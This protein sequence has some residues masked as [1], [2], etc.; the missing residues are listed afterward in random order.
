M[1]SPSQDEKLL[2]LGE[3]VAQPPPVP[4]GHPDHRRGHRDELVGLKLDERCGLGLANAGRDEEQRRGDAEHRGE[5][6]EHGGTRLLD[7]AGL[8]LRDRRA[9]D[10]DAARQLS[11]SEVQSLARGS[12]RERQGRS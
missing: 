9:R 6:C 12:H 8:K 10:T 3:S 5:A 4:V 11:L 1:T 2:K 7:A